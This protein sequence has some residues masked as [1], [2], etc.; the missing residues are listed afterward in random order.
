MLENNIQNLKEFQYLIKS[1]V[2]VVR[3]TASVCGPCRRIEESLINF[4]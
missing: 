4:V 3:F 1:D 2:V